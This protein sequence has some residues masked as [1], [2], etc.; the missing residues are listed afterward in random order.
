MSGTGNTSSPGVN[1]IAI[2]AEWE[3]GKTSYRLSQEYPITRQGID[4]RAKAEGWSRGEGNQQP[5]GWL[6]VAEQTNIV[7]DDRYKATP[8]RI[9]A[10]L[11]AVNLGATYELSARANGIDV[12]TLKR[13]RDA[14]PAF[15]N[16]L[17]VAQ[18]QDALESIENIKKAGKRGDWKA[19]AHRLAHHPLTKGEYGNTGA[20]GITIVLN[21]PREPIDTQ[22]PLEGEVIEA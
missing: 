20:G 11:E 15:E 9:A 22:A 17:E 19:D 5:G 7:S 3:S 13:W 1:W 21:I 12:K 2:K 6:A 18:A 10:I 14:D 8:K 16:A 4:K